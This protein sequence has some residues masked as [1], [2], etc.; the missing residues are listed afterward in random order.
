MAIWIVAEEYPDKIIDLRGHIRW[1]KHDGEPTSVFKYGLE[2]TRQD[3]DAYR[4][5]ARMI[6]MH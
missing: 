4:T 3:S 1:K 6:A 5:F 2:F